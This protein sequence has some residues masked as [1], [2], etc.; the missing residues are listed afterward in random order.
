M[1]SSVSGVS[2]AN[3]VI[4]GPTS[5]NLVNLFYSIVWTSWVKLLIGKICASL[6]LSTTGPLGWIIGTAVTSI[7]KQLFLT[8]AMFADVTSIRLIN[9][10]HQAQFDT[11]SER[12]GIVA[13]EF[14]PTSTEFQK[15]H[16]EE[17]QAF[18]NLITIKVNPIGI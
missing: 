12:L 8:L 6:F 17:Q 16:A 1:N 4:A 14:G 5:N 10:I 2:P 7:S 18:Y 3:P 13:A 11:A 9:A 15:A